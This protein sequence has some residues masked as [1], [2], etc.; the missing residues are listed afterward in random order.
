MYISIEPLRDGKD[1]ILSALDR[2]FARWLKRYKIG[3][4]E[5]KTRPDVIDKFRREFE[6]FKKSI[7]DFASSPVVNVV[8]H[9]DEYCEKLL[10]RILSKPYYVV[11]CLADL[12]L[13]SVGRDYDTFMSHIHLLYSSGNPVNRSSV[14]SLTVGCS[15]SV[16]GVR[17]I[18][19][20][21]IDLKSIDLTDLDKI[22][23]GMGAIIAIVD[24]VK[25][26]LIS[27]W[28]FKDEYEID[29]CIVDVV[30]PRM[31]RPT[32][33]MLTSVPLSSFLDPN[34]PGIDPKAVAT[35]II[36]TCLLG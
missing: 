6:E 9:I 14:I 18:K 31:D 22:P 16:E 13:S 8:T 28:A 23:I 34:V 5:P 29:R 19:L 24:R 26:E 15:V 17:E 25:I 27:G 1:L 33:E 3:A 36:M 21:Y 30:S 2:A 4:P 32:E 7:E 20:S 12:F 11:K 35:G 10:K